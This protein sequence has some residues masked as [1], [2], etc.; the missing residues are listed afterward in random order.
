MATFARCFGLIATSASLM[1]GCQSNPDSTV[2]GPSSDSETKRAASGEAEGAADEEERGSDG[3][4]SKT[5]AILP[6]DGTGQNGSPFEDDFPAPGPAPSIQTLQLTLDGI[7]GTAATTAKVGDTVTCDWEVT[8]DACPTAG[9]AA[10]DL[11][12]VDYAWS[13]GAATFATSQDYVVDSA[14]VD[15]LDTLT[16][17]LTVEDQEGKDQEVC[18]QG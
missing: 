8:D 5:E 13:I 2:R 14:N 4:F 1:L 6:G 16:C 3:A 12:S 9:C 17:E 7:G 15:V 10:G 11:N 18:S